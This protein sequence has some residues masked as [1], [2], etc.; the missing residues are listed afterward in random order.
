MA[1]Y[2]FKEKDSE[3][4]YNLTH[5]LQYMAENNINEMTVLKAKIV[6]DSEFFYCTEVM[7]V[8]EKNGTCGKMCEDYRPRNSKSG[9]CKYFR[10]TYENTGIVKKLK[11]KQ[12]APTNNKL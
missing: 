9:I 1:T 11:L 5:H 4:C 12:N 3:M 6:N 2:Y 8:G 10:N 7:E